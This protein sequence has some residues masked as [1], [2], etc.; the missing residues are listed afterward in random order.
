MPTQRLLTG[1][2]FPLCFRQA[3]MVLGTSKVI[4]LF[5]CWDILRPVFYTFE[6]GQRLRNSVSTV[7][8]LLLDR[9]VLTWGIPGG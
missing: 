3:C 9:L 1:V 4:V 2:D 7:F 5:M 8:I 6:F